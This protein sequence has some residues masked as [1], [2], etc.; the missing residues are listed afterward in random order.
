MKIIDESGFTTFITQVRDTIKENDQILCEA[1]DNDEDFVTGIIHP[2]I[3]SAYLAGDVT[4][5]TVAV[6]ICERL[7]VQ[8]VDEDEFLGGTLELLTALGFVDEIDVDDID[9]DNESR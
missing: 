1:L 4:A 7:S 5:K 2:Y 8:E 9:K 3:S 6:H